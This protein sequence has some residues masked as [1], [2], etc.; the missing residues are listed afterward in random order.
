MHERRKAPSIEDSYAL[1][2]ANLERMAAQIEEN[3]ELIRDQNYSIKKLQDDVEEAVTDIK[4]HKT[5]AKQVIEDHKF[6]GRLRLFFIGIFGV[7]AA[8]VAFL[9]QTTEM[10]D[11][12]KG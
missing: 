8:I 9:H 6:A 12:F 11:R 2:F 1:I 5:V 3:K 4:D 7:I 10:F